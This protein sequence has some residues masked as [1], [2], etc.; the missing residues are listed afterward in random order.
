MFREL[1]EEMGHQGT[2]RVLSLARERFYWPNMQRD[3]E[4]TITKKCNCIKQKKPARQLRVPMVPII[5]HQPFELISID[6]LHLEKS[7]GNFE[8]ILVV[9]DHYTR[10]TQAYATTNKTA[11]TAAE[12]LFNDFFLR[13]GF[14]ERLHHDQGKEFENNLFK[15]LQK[16]SGVKG[17]RTTPYHP[18]TDGLVERFNQTLK[19]MLKKLID[20]EGREWHKLIPYVLFAY[21]EVPQ[22]STG[23]SPFELIYGRDVRGPLDVLRDA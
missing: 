6:F 20:G 17:S 14:P 2:D 11:K 5:T 7:K 15:Q 8:Y 21:R 22:S 3:I 19:Q 13:F 10:F 23:F 4:E 1:H 12:K 18:Q 16:L 9:M